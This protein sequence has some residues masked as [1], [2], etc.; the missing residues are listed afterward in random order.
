MRSLAPALVLI[1]LVTFMPVRQANSSEPLMWGFALDGYPVSVQMLKDV[2][3]ETG[4]RPD[5]VVFFLQWPSPEDIAGQDFPLGSLETIWDSGAVPCITWEPMYYKGSKEIMVPYKDLLEG[6]YDT[7]IMRFAEKAKKWGKPFIIR[8]AHEMNIKRYHWGTTEDEYGP[9]SPDIY[10]KMFRYIVNLFRKAGANNALWAFC[11]NAESVPNTSYDPSSSWNAI[12]N[13]YPGR[14]YVDILG[15]DGYNWGTTRNRQQHGWESRWMSF[16]DIF[17]PAYRQL[18]AL[19]PAGSIKPV[20]IFETSTAGQGGNRGQWIRDAVET[21]LKLG[22]KGIVWFQSNKELDWRIN[23]DFNK[24][25]MSFI[26]PRASFAHFWFKR[27]KDTGK[28]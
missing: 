10:K 7:Y 19:E 27:L 28:D 14:E 12:N 22:I 18:S 13:Y 21:S 3:T 11:P 4:L 26:R 1:L 5:I 6:G 16:R 23:A 9:G 8:F 25:Y 15:I 20:F 2:E 17:E 24:D